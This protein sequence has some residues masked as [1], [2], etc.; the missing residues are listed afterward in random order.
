MGGSLLREAISPREEERVGRV[1]PRA[2]HGQ[3]AAVRRGQARA[4]CCREERPGRMLPGS[5]R[6]GDIEPTATCGCARYGSW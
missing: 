6:G 5:E 4:G 2:E 3:G 1:W